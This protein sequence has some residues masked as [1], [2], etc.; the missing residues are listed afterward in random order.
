[1][2]ARYR[3]DYVLLKRATQPGDRYLDFLDADSSF[4]LVFVDDVAALY[5]A[6]RPP[7]LDTVRGFAYRRLPAGDAALEAAWGRAMRDSSERRLLGDELERAIA[8]SPEHVVAASL[9][10]TLGASPR[11]GD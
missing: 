9:R 7:F 3:F 1:M 2:A 4:A 8:S 5:I 10:D 6:R 11:A